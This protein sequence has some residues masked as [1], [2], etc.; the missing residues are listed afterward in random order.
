MKSKIS[1][2]LLLC[3]AI[4]TNVS[5][6][7]NAKADKPETKKDA[8][9][10]KK[11]ESNSETKLETATL[12]AGCYWCIEAVLERTNGIKTVVSGFMGGEIENPTYNQVCSGTTGHAEVVQLTFD[13]SVISFEKLIESFWKLHDPTTLNRQGADEGTQYRSVIFYHSDAQKKIA[14]ESKKK[15]A[16]DFTDPIVTE[17]SKAEKFYEAKGEHQ[18]FLTDNPYHGYSNAV[19]WPKLKKL[20]LEKNEP[21]EK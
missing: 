11:S 15:H 21:S 6:I 16:K 13:P 18:N 5:C 19:I 1:T 8:A 3:A 2:L 10:E 20:G 12:G 17:I 14:E 9:E 4:F 7:D